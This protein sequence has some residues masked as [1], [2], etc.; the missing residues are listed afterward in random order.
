ML[1]IKEWVKTH[2][3]KSYIT[4]DAIITL[5]NAICK[6]FLHNFAYAAEI[7]SDTRSAL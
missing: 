2:S 1:N 4:Y 6:T 5:I 3:L 7:I